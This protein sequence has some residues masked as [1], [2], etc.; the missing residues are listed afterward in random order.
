MPNCNERLFSELTLNNFQYIL[1]LNRHERL[2]KVHLSKSLNHEWQS[3]WLA[4]CCITTGKSAY[5]LSKIHQDTKQDFKC[6]Y[7]RG[8]TKNENICVKQQ[9]SSTSGC[10]QYYITSFKYINR[11]KFNNDYGTNHHRTCNSSCMN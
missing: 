2:F 5:Y 7:L 1:S 11:Y 4:K 10:M 3:N 6:G 8:R 9:S